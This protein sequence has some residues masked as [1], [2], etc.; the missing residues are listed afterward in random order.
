MATQAL[1]GVPVPLYQ[2]SV[3]KQ[4]ACVVDLPEARFSVVQDQEQVDKLLHVKALCPRLEYVIYLEP[5]GLRGYDEPCLLSLAELR[6]R[7]RRYA[8]SHPGAFEAE[9]DRGRADDT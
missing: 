9:M 1:G 2:D 5:R 3:E 4:L 7:G 6:E 8:E